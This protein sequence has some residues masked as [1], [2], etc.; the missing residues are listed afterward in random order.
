MAVAS[1]PRPPTQDQL[2]ALIP[3]ARDRERR[4]RL[5]AAVALG[6]SIGL[7]LALWAAVSE[8]GPVTARGHGPVTGA[9]GHVSNTSEVRRG[10]DDVGSAG[11]VTWAINGRGIWLT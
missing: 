10:I 1:P 7:G 2:D 6:I 8:G 11:G 5:L 3:E 4:R 9:V